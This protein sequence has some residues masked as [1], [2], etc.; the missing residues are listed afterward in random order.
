MQNPKESEQFGRLPRGPE[1]RSPPGA[2]RPAELDSAHQLLSPHWTDI[3][4]RRLV[5]LLP[6]GVAELDLDGNVTYCNPACATLLAVNSEEMLGQPIWD[7]C[8]NT[9]EK[10]QLR[11]AVA[12]WLTADGGPT[13]Q[14]AVVMGANGSVSRVLLQGNIRRDIHGGATGVVLAIMPAEPTAASSAESSR[15]SA[16][17]TPTDS[18]ERAEQ[19][20]AALAKSV[21]R[22]EQEIDQRRAA[23]AAQS[24]LVAILET[25]PDF[26]GIADAEHRVLYINRGGRVMFGIEAD[27][28]V[29]KLTLADLT[30]SRTL[31]EHVEERLP[32]A[33]HETYWQ[34]ET[35]LHGRNG[36][37][38]PVSQVII[39]HRDVTGKVA[40]FSTIARDLS[41]RVADE[42]ALRGQH[43]RMRDI[44]DGMMSFAALLA[45]DGTVLEINQR[46]LEKT[47]FSRQDIIGKHVADTH[48][49]NYSAESRKQI[50]DELAKAAAGQTTTFDAP[51]RGRDDNFMPA[52]GSFVPLFDAAGNVTEIVASG[53]DM[54]ARQNAEEAARRHL[55]D[56]AHV[57]RVTLLGEMVGGIAHELNQPLAAIANYADACSGTLAQ[58]DWQAIANARR[59][60]ERISDEA[61]RAGA[62]IR[63]LRNL[64]RKTESQRALAEVNDLLREVIDLVRA[65][66]RMRQIR[67]VTR[68]ADGLPLLPIDRIQIQ[69]VVL[70]LLSN[71]FEALSDNAGDDRVIEIETVRHDDGTVEISVVDNGR[72]FDQRNAERLFDAFYT[73]KPD[74]LGLGL[75]TSR[76]I[77][78]AHGGQLWAESIAPSGAA[79]RLRLPVATGS[80]TTKRG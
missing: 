35:L 28:D 21:A 34:G 77:A 41:D 7:R 6:C 33:T 20:A 49:W 2:G 25:T 30:T 9:H 31:T 22:L 79:F 40:Y 16:P 19:R 46:V 67:I 58:G 65:D 10:E 8:A 54:T 62:I 29:S 44:L 66:A 39:A 36:R 63:G 55:N 56:L 38:I 11:A 17:P 48:W 47:G 43:R 53:I 45:L 15:V 75:S 14:P 12:G 71:S 57:S 59:T 32:T 69:Q 68:L 76:A 60:M 23:E 13:L 51:C 5:E 27:E 64:L 18:E 73:S 37:S 80:D 50:I 52:H 78:T 61:L 70:N 1:M 4:G 72:G 74:G 42:A 24:R 3:P 26:V